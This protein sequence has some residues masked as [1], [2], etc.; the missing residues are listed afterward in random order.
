MSDAAHENESA[1][2]YEVGYHIIPVSGKDTESVVNE[3]RETITASGGT[4]IAEGAPQELH[5]SYTMYVNNEGKNTAYDKTDFGWMK[6]E[7]PS[8]SVSVIEAALKA[9]PAVLRSIVFKT[10]KEETRATIKIGSLREVKRT[11]T[12]KTVARKEVSGEEVS[13][14]RLDEALEDITNES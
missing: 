2:V 10:V 5:L 4:L 8:G 14:E 1:R 7:I 6:F 9:H 13:E 12:L 11:D 3:I